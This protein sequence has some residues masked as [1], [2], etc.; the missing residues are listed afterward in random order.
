M[1][2]H[3]LQEDLDGFVQSC[4]PGAK[5]SFDVPHGS[6]VR[7]APVS[8]GKIAQGSHARPHR[9][10]GRKLEHPAAHTVKVVRRC[11]SAPDRRIL[12]TDLGL[13]GVANTAKRVLRI[14]KV[15]ASVL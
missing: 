10:I 7:G 3:Q 15:L 11:D 9:P 1:T 13:Q 12:P 8:G 2:L 6:R 5:V 4:S 14:V